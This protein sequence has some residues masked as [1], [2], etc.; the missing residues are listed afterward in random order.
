[1]KVYVFDQKKNSLKKWNVE[2]FGKI[3]EF[4]GKVD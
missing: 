3:V 4:F 2:F 1:V